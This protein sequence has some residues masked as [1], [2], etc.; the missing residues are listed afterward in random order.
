MYIIGI[1]PGLNNC[2]VSI[3]SSLSNEIILMKL[4]KTPS[5][6]SIENK[7]EKLVQK[8]SFIMKSLEETMLSTRDILSED[9]YHVAIEDSFVN[10]NS[11][12]SLML[13]MVQG[14]IIG[15][16]VL[17]NIKVFIYS[18]TEVKKTISSYGSA[19]KEDVRFFI[20]NTMKISLIDIERDISEHEIDSVA[21]GLTHIYSYNL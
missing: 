9:N 7:K 17:K 18:P 4:I 3:I 14:A 15:F 21:T 1:D 8:I 20:L 2:G 13:S 11:K 16:F 6:S 5:L 19:S 10:V 12:T